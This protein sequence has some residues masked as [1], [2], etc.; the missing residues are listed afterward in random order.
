MAALHETTMT[1]RFFG[2]DLDPDEVTARLGCLPTFGAKKGGIWITKRGAE[3][4]ARTGFWRIAVENRQPGD[5]DAQIAELLEQCSDDLSAWTDLTAQFTANVFC[6][7]F[8]D[9]RNEGA[10]LSPESMRLLGA[11]NLPL[12]FDIY[13]LTSPD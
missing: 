12:W 4:V 1:L 3:K 11:R 7:V 9:E 10:S 5:L 8:M 6:G 13:D 2:D